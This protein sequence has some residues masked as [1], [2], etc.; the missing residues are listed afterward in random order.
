MQILKG[1]LEIKANKQT[2]NFTDLV[3]SLKNLKPDKLAQL[4]TFINQ[5]NG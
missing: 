2:D 5:L 4:T 1:K 3:E